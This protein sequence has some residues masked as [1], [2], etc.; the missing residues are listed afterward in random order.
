MFT[1]TRQCLL[2]SHSSSKCPNC[3]KDIVTQSTTGE[4]E[5]LCSVTDEGGTEQNFDILPFLIEEAYFSDHP[6]ERRCRAFL[7]FCR[8]GDLQAIL[9]LLDD[10]EKTIVWPAS[11]RI[12][13]LRYQ[14]PIG[15]R[16]SGLHAAI[17]GDSQEIAWLLLFLAS[18]LDLTRFPQEV[19]QEVEVLGLAREDENSKPDIRC[20]PDAHGKLPLTIAEEKGG[21]WASWKGFLAT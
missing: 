17:D 4:Q 15:D 11:S 2:E 8:E 18:K 14:D 7:E 13:I 10:Y 16:R 9:Q 12:D 1:E 3:D 20:L 21:I 19:I 5:A 6:E